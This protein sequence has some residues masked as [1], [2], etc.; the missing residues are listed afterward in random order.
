MDSLK[1]REVTIKHLGEFRLK[2]W[3]GSM[4]GVVEGNTYNHLQVEGHAPY[5]IGEDLL[6]RN[7]SMGLWESTATSESD[8]VTVSVDL[9]EQPKE[10][11]KEMPNTQKKEHTSLEEQA[12]PVTT[13]RSV[14]VIPEVMKDLTDRLAK[15]VA[16]YGK[17]LQSHNGRDALQDAY[18]ELL[19]GACYLKQL[20]MEREA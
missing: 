18:E 4:V 14:N 10:E 2:T 6:P 16:T 3:T 5:F 11:G 12:N 9:F 1:A 19:D 17:P 13:E 15:G 20:M 7:V 8:T